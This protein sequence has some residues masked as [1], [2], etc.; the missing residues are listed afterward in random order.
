M[1]EA[2]VAA[3]VSLPLPAAVPL[4]GAA[5]EAAVAAA[6]SALESASG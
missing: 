1:G 6:P 4:R 5:V 2:A 3:A